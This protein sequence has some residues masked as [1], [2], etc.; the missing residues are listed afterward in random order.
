[1][2]NQLIITPKTKVLQLIETYPQLEETLIGY[3]PAFEKLKNPLLRKTVARIATL[4]QAAAIGNVS[5]DELINKL[6][7]EIGQDL[8]NQE[9]NTTYNQHK[10]D[11]FNESLIA[12]Q[13]DARAMLTA[14]EHPVNQV[15]ADLK[16]LEKGKIYQLTAP[17][18][19]APLIDKASSLNFDHW[20][21]KGAGDAVVIYFI[22]K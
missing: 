3:V 4:Q 1:M 5:V 11:W 16:Q 10:P 21:S 2:E 8:M 6:R 15:I 18:L 13:L 14:G 19:P 9:E 12:G 17:F 20:V 22:S 7:N